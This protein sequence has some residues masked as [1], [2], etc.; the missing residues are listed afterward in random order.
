MSGFDGKTFAA[1]LSTRPGVYRMQNEAGDALYVGK[2]HNLRKR[3]AS[4]FTRT[5]PNN[6]I[7]SMLTQV[8]HIEVTVTRTEAEA[9]LLE[10][11][12]IKELKPRYNVLLRD[13]KSYPYIYLSS[14]DPYPRLA[15][16]RGARRLPG[17]FFGPFPSAYAVRDSLNQMQKLFRVRQCEDTFFSNRTRPCLQYQIRRCTAPCV[18]AISEGDYARDVRHAELFLEGKDTQVIDELGA[19]MA[20][21]S[22]ALEFEKA[23]QIRD[24]IANLKRVQSQQYVLGARGHVD[25]VAVAADG[26]TACVLVMYFREGRNVGSRSF[27]PRNQAEAGPDEVLGAFLLQYYSRQEVPRELIVDRDFPDRELLAEVLGEKAGHRLNILY[28][29]RGDKSKWLSMARSNAKAALASHLSGKAGMHQ[30]VENLAQVLDLPAPPERIECFDISHTQGEATVAACVVFDNEGPRKSD[31]RRFNIK[32]ITPGDDYAALRQA[33]TRRYQ[34]IQ[35]GEG[36]LPDLLLIDGGKGQL[37]QGIEVM[38]ELGI[39]SVLLVGVAKGPERR[40]GEETL[41]VGPERRVIVPPGDS[42]ASHLIQ[43]IRDEA[44]RFA[45]TGHRQRRARQRQTSVL[46]EIPGIGAAKRR[47]ILRHFGG[48]KGVR[49]AGVEELCAVDG[50]SQALARRIYDALHD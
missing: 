49:R 24:Q 3:V 39:D 31:Y 37:T 11:Q 27:F 7:A 35:K 25:I 13:D 19:D 1:R 8:V 34:R 20:E 42:A 45:I 38:T 23:A 29:P 16:H 36:Q 26:P 9:L 4:Y 46:E 50:V 14:K 33:F 15:F 32:G 47:Q 28:R 41:F 40:G 10:N 21:A 2:A 48:L 5:V 6:R 43:A 30:R 12:L 17:R 22:K 18:G 44:H